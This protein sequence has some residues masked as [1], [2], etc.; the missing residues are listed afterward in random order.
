MHLV[1]RWLPV[2]RKSWVVFDP[3]FILLFATKTNLTNIY[4]SA[5]YSAEKG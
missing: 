4:Q 1:Y 3:K 5:R 2:P